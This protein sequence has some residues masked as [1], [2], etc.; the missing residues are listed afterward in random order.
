VTF[1]R[2]EGEKVVELSLDEF[3]DT[4]E[5]VEPLPKQLWRDALSEKATLSTV[6]L[7]VASDGACFETALLTKRGVIVFGRYYTYK[8][9]EVGHFIRKEL[10]KRLSQAVTP[11]EKAQ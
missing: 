9:A 7:P 6:F 2:L 4:Y 1:F 11:S 5:G 8:D 10:G 3:K